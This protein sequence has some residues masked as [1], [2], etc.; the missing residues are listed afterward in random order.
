MKIETNRLLLRALQQDDI[1]SLVKLWLDPDVTSFMGGSRGKVSLKEG[2]KEDI[3]NPPSQSDDLWPVIEKSSS[4]VI[5]HCGLLE[6][7]IEENKETELIYIFHKSAWGK[8]YATEIG[9]ALIAHA[10]VKLGLKN[11]V[12]LIDPKNV[13]SEKVAKKLGMEYIKT[14]LRPNGKEMKIY[15]VNLMVDRKSNG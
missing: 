10:K 11:L 6:K 3:N 9:N 12:A 4:T 2:F 1:S 7:N 14:I 8:Q 15:S 5:G 13:A